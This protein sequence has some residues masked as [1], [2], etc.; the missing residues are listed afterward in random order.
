MEA[1]VLAMILHPDTM[2]RAQAQIDQVVGRDRL[3]A[4]TDLEDL[5]YI[6]AVVREILRWRPPAPLCECILCVVSSD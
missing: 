5:P 2:K 6:Q 3:P 1:F 4:F